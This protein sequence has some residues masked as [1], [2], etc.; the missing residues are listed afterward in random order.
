MKSHFS[1]LTQ[2][3]LVTKKMPFM[4]YFVDGWDDTV[5]YFYDYYMC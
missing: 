3:M 4:S 1:N 2:M 5:L